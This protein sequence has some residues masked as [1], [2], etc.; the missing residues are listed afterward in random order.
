MIRNKMKEKE[1]CAELS[2]VLTDYE[3]F[4]CGNGD[5]HTTSKKIKEIFSKEHNTSISQEIYETLVDVIEKTKD[6]FEEELGLYEIL[7]K[8]QNNWIELSLS[9][10]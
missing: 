4:R 3:E 1:I 8:I 7:V 5:L 2:R 9:I 10:D 6:N